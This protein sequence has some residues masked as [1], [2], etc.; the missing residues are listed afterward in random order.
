MVRVDGEVYVVV[1]RDGVG[2]EVL[3]GERDGELRSRRDG[4][5]N[6]GE[7]CAFIEGGYGVVGEEGWRYSNRV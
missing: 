5:W 7:G 6:D 2:R 1:Q 3:K 4:G